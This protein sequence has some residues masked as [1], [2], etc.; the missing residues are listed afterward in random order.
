MC[1]CAEEGG[2]H[3]R[4]DSSVVNIGGTTYKTTSQCDNLHLKTIYYTVTRNRK[5]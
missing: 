1:G 3:T 2:V 5:Q 4:V